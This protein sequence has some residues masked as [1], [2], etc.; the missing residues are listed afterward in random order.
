MTLFFMIVQGDDVQ[1]EEDGQV[2]EPQPE[3]DFLVGSDTDD[4]YEPLETGTFHEGR[5]NNQ[6]FCFR[7]KH[8][9]L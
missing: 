7:M 8:N 5:K 9:S 2:R 3:D 6:H 1:Q 4:R